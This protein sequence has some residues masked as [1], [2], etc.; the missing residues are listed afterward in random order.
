MLQSPAN[1]L[2]SLGSA[3]NT[4]VDAVTRG[5]PQEKAIQNAVLA[6]VA[7]FESNRLFGGTP[8]EDASKKGYVTKLGEHIAEKAGKSAV[9]NDFMRTGAGKAVGWTAEKAGE[10]I[11]EIVTGF[12]NPV[13][14]R[15]TWNPEADLATVDDLWKQFE[16]GVALS[17]LMS[18]G[19]AVIDNTGKAVRN[20]QTPIVETAA[21]ETVKPLRVG[22]A[23]TIYNPYQGSIPVQTQSSGQIVEVPETA[24]KRAENYTQQAQD[25]AYVRH[26][27]K[28]GQTIRYDYF[29]TPVQIGEHQYL[30]LFDVS[31]E[32]SGN[33]Y[34]THKIKD[35]S[36]L[37]QFADS[38]VKVT[39]TA[40]AATDSNLG[41]GTPTASLADSVPTASVSESSLQRNYIPQSTDDVNPPT[42]PPLVDAVLLR[43]LLE[44]KAAPPKL[45]PEQRRRLKQWNELFPEMF[46]TEE[47]FL[48]R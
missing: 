41:L 18:G 48:R 29:E 1:T 34:R 46:M 8:L 43:A 26:G 39:G 14:E 37:P 33:N 17:L 9:L 6:G 2:I 5:A 7:E 28:Q 31:V 40:N 30:A 36:L 15:I 4:Y 45:T 19:E 47:E 21:P 13:F 12:L 22:R 35:L 3:G 11:E 25:A 27:A 38:P 23:T 24:I 32:H 20:Q 10:G 44:S 16:G 42:V